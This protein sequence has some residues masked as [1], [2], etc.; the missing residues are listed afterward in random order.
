M[1]SFFELIIPSDVQSIVFADIS[2]LNKM[3]DEQEVLFDI[4]TTFIVSDVT[5]ADVEQTW[6]IR[7]IGSD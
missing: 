1:L 5:Y 2:Y 6:I 7:L 4:G 3:I